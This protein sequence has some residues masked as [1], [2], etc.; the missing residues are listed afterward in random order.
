M[1]RPLALD[2]LLAHQAWVSRLARQLA[3]DHGDDVAQEVWLAALRSPPDPDRPARPWLSRVLRNFA[4]RRW[5][6]HDRIRR[7]EGA[8]PAPDPMPGIDQVYERMEVQ[9]RLAAEV[10]ALE[11]PLRTIVVLRFVEDLDAT[12]IG[13]I[14][15]E[16]AGTVRW[17]LKT[18]LD[19][20]RAA[21]DRDCGDRRAW[22][23]ALAPG[24][25]ASTLATGALFMA[26]LKL[27][28]S[29]VV[30]VL[31]LL[32]LGGST[33]ALRHRLFAPPPETAAAPAGA[34]RART[35]PH[36]S[37]AAAAL[38]ATAGSLSGVVEDEAGRPVENAVVL[39]G[40]S[41]PQGY[42]G[43]DTGGTSAPVASARD[44]SF[45]IG[46]LRPGHYRA[47]ATKAGLGAARG[48]TVAVS[49]SQEV[50]GIRLRLIRSAAGLSGR[51]VD[52]GGGGISRARVT[53]SGQEGARPLQFTTV[54]DDE[55]RYTL[56][57]PPER[58]EFQADADGY[59]PAR[60]WTHLHLPMV[61]DFRLHPASRLS[62]RVVS[63]PDGAPLP[64]A[65]VWASGA[66]RGVSV[67]ADDQGAFSF[68][69][70]EPGA[71]RL[72]GRSGPHVGWR[73]APITVGLA[74]TLSDVELRLPRGRTISGFVRRQDHTPAPD[75]A[76]VL[77][78][79]PPTRGRSDA[80]GAFRL[81]GAPAAAGDLTATSGPAAVRRRVDLTAADVHDLELVLQ[82]EVAVSGRVLD[83]ARAPVPGARVVAFTSDPPSA[84]TLT[85]YSD[86]QGRFRVSG[87]DPGTASLSATRGAAVADVVTT[88]VG[89]DSPATVD[90]LLTAGATIAGTVRDEAGR[91]A[92]GTQVFAFAGTAIYGVPRWPQPT[93]AAD[94][95]ADGSYTLKGLPSADVVVRACRRGDDPF[96]GLLGRQRRPDSVS[97]SLRAA[98]KRTGVDLVVLA[99]DLRIEGRVL[100]RAGRPVAGAMLQ[101]LADG[102]GAPAP[103]ARTL[104]QADGQFVIEGLSAGPYTILTLH[105]A[106]ADHRQDHIAAGARGLELRLQ[107]PAGLAGVVV[108]SD[109]RPVTEYTILGRPLLGPRAGEP[110][111][112]L[113]W[114]RP[115]L[116]ALVSRADGTFDF[117]RVSPGVYELDAY[118]PDRTSASLPAVTVTEG[119][120]QSGLRL[121][122]G[123]SASVRGRVIDYRTGRPIA[124][125]RAEGRGTASGQVT[126]T[127]DAAGV[128]VLEGLPA[129]RRVDFAVVS[130][131]SD[132]LTD[133]Q[134]RQTPATGGVLEIGDV[135]LFPGSNQVLGARGASSTGVWFQSEEGRP[136]VYSVRPGSPGA[137]AGLR[138]GELV[139]AV[140]AVD[141]RNT[142]S[143]VVEGL[144]ASAGAEIALTLQSGG[145]PRRLIVTR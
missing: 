44:G 48:E 123:P 89:R 11:E 144:V 83:G 103:Q 96:T 137:R 88:Q 55:G 129:G 8:C 56:T 104:S 138:G 42:A 15:G 119:Q 66:S 97:L 131:R 63:E 45:H 19:R 118:L 95:D 10:M 38:S 59:A 91:P 14:L 57:I 94:A 26:K 30:A 53:A 25:V 85:A 65:E 40:T 142:S 107:R 101:A 139:I 58:Y 72:G 99:N 81:E 87:L 114:S 115:P 141:A 98:E 74:E 3:G 106:F 20:L 7:R 76:L 108:R 82:A 1:S 143:S 71:H 5:R 110:E 136:A 112:R 54:A 80:R 117:P 33:V 135:P 120:Q 27:E 32:L 64:G 31:L 75:A 4:H 77:S 23:V 2:Q 22:M 145:Q 109:G 46:G 39:A 28:V 12:R 43:Q 41:W 69:D 16:P 9:R 140:D 102:V 67:L 90:L 34:E 49:P 132:Y 78:S 84:R 100:D 133:S 113:A 134:H 51:V 62:G 29:L 125:A 111:L 18:A 73:P 24:P 127:T 124:G 36:L 79:D 6:D 130:P 122:A 60:F 86:A 50:R 35:G 128:F 47:T 17:R 68:L 93:A 121:V 126:A 92:A 52:S 61:R 70:L 13:Q 105:P 116:R 21:M 37:A